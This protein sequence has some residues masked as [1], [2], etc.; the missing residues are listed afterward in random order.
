MLEKN[1]LDGAPFEQRCFGTGETVEV[2]C[3]LVF[4]SIGYRGVPMPG[5]PF[6]EKRGLIPNDEGRIL[7]DG[8]PAPGSYVVGWIKR[9]PTGI[10]GENKPDSARVVQHLMEDVPKLKPCEKP[11]TDAL[12]ASIRE[13]GVRIVTLEDWHKIDQAEIERG[14]AVGKPRER[15]TRIDE[16]LAV[17]D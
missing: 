15:F 6:D 17:L 7:K 14:Q 10:L 2:P 13:R 9:G 5:V 1:Q 11:D 16:M 12:L 3:G 8:A 4:R